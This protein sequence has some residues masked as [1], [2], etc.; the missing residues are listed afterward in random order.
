[1]AYQTAFLPRPGTRQR[2]PMP[3]VP[4]ARVEPPMAPAERACLERRLARTERALASAAREAARWKATALALQGALPVPDPGEA[5]PP[6]NRTGDLAGLPPDLA[7]CAAIV[8]GAAGETVPALRSACRS[9]KTATARHLVFWLARRTS[10][11]SLAAI[12]APFGRDHATVL[13]GIRRCE[14]VALA[15]GI[16]GPLP[17]PKEAVRALLGADWQRMGRL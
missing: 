5:P 1:M 6:A 7:A 2:P 11:L 15:L 13:Y 9:R 10:S 8:C 3:V 16:S 17:S 14:A 12:G 4:R